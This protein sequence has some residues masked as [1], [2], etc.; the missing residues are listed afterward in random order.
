V[1]TGSGR[2]DIAAEREVANDREKSGGT[3]AIDDFVKTI[4]PLNTQGAQS[5]RSCY[6][7]LQTSE[8]SNKSTPGELDRVANADSLTAPKIG[9]RRSEEASILSSRFMARHKYLEEHSLE[10]RGGFVTLARGQTRNADSI[11]FAGRAREFW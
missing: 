3:L 6:R 2:V 1:R 7:P 9:T 4:H 11:P 10:R 8:A 5:G